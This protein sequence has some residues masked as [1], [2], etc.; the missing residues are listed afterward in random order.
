[1]WTASE[2]GRSSYTTRWVRWWEVPGR[3]EKWKE[4]CI[5]DE[6]KGDL[7]Y[8]SQEFDA[9]FTTGGATFIGPSGE[10]W[11]NSVQVPPV[12]EDMLRGIKYF[13]E[14]IVDHSYVISIDPAEGKG[15]NFH[16]AMIFDVTELPF[17]CVCTY[18]DNQSDLVEMPYIVASLGR[19]YNDAFMLI[20]NNNTG[21]GVARDLM[22]SLEYPNLYTTVI[23][24]PEIKRK[25]TEPGIRT[26]QR[27]K[28][29]GQDYSKNLLDNG[30][31]LVPDIQF[32]VELD[33]LVKNSTTQLWEAN[34][35]AINDDLYSAF[36][37]FAFFVKTEAF[38]NALGKGVKRNSVDPYSQ[39]DKENTD[40][41]YARIFIRCD[42]NK[43]SSFSKKKKRPNMIRIGEMR[44]QDDSFRM[45]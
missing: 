25:F 21:G 23:D 8:F 6:C 32:H 42:G 41:S 9:A 3:D 37:L 34:D 29:L 11:L 35:E 31:V 18:K 17:R 38:E 33:N 12:R 16:A 1:M 40:E 19:E 27:V 45:R 24:R 28:R 36:R 13:E 22:N 10:K 43:K 39:K 30:K 14:P 4:A 20:E 26:T 7:E 15:L 44:Y 5:R 2:K